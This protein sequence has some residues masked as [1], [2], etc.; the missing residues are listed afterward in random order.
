[1]NNRNEISNGLQACFQR[2]LREYQ[3]ENNEYPSYVVIFR[4]G[5]GDGQLNACLQ[6]EIPQLQKCLDEVQRDPRHNGSVIDLCFVVVQK[7]I[8]TRF[9]AR[10]QRD[11]FSNPP[12]GTVLDFEI[13]RKHYNDFFLVSQ[14]V[15]QGTINPVHYIVLSDTKN[16]DPDRIQLLTFKM[17]HLYYNWPGTIRVPAPC[18][19]AH[20]F[21]YL[22]GQNIRKIPATELSNRLYYL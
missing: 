8:N 9:F 4:D 2:A 19:Y 1:M 14:H 15:R 18:Q 11:G 16:T 5:V 22:I 6:F 7:R 20:K 10:E 21:A 12:P 17:C 3:S 13:T